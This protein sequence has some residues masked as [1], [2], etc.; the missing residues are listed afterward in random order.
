MHAIVL[1]TSGLKD[2]LAEVLPAR[3]IAVAF[4]FGS[5]A[6][7]SGRAE[8]DLDLM[9]VGDVTHRTVASGLRTA[10]ERIGREI[11]P[12]FFPSAEFRRRNAAGDHFLGDVMAK[13]KLFIVRGERELGELVGRRMAATARDKRDE[14]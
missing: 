4:V 7:A 13:P 5:L 3:K 9:I 12:H 2:V 11:N 10:G 14:P 6:A 8:S 1:K